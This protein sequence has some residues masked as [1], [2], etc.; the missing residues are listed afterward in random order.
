MFRNAINPLILTVVVFGICTPVLAQNVGIGTNVPAQKLHVAGVG[1]TIRV[2]GLTGVGIRTVYANAN[3]DLTVTPGSPAP[4]WMTIGNAGT[5]AAINFIG[6]TDPVDWVIRTNNIEQMRVLS[7]GNVGIGIAAP[8]AKLHVQVTAGVAIRGTQTGF[9]SGYLG[10]SGAIS[11]GSFGAPPG[12]V[13]FSEE[14]TASSNPS[15]IAVTRNPATYAANISYSDV[16]IAGYFG[17]DNPSTTNNPP[18]IYGQLNELSNFGS[19]VFQNAIAG[20]MNRGAI[21]GNGAYSVGLSGIAS[22][23]NQDAFGVI[24]RTY[25][26][27]VSASNTGAYFESNN[28]AG[29]NNAFAYVANAG[30]NRKIA[31]SGTVSEI[32][33]TADH[34]RIILTCPESP[35]YWYQ[36]YGTVELVNG[37]AHVDLDPILADI[38]IVN[39]ENPIR[40]F[41]TPV[42][43]PAFNGVSMLNRNEKGFDIAELNGG[44]HNGTLE[45]QLIVKPR[46]NYGEGR[47]MQAPGPAGLKPEQEPLKAKAKNQPDVSKIWRWP[48][49]QTVYGY[50]IP[51]QEPLPVSKKQDK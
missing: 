44:S 13:V 18:C 22:S 41:F 1:Q 40:A 37:K 51:K 19:V 47:F 14:G 3:G 20:Y 48:S 10:Y 16:W 50:S 33:P 12:A 24:G 26:N 2:D 23:A 17:V 27:S 31:G 43:M 6:T 45:F 32:I 49:D 29:V 15:L 9:G 39:A 46:T 7:T 8:L 30:L 28:Y 34:G 21:A 35:E 25:C 36:D 4:N 11:L 38:I 5:S 42:D